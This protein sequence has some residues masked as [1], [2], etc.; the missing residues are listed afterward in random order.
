M[1]DLG[2]GGAQTRFFTGGGEPML[3][4]PGGDP[5]GRNEFLDRLKRE[6][7]GAEDMLRGLR[8]RGADYFMDASGGETFTREQSLR[9]QELKEQLVELDRLFAQPDHPDFLGYGTEER[10]VARDRYRDAYEEVGEISSRQQRMMFDDLRADPS[11]QTASPNW[12]GTKGS[13]GPEGPQTFG[14]G[15]EFFPASDANINAAIN[16]GGIIQPGNPQGLSGGGMGPPP[17]AGRA[18]T[19]A[20]GPDDFKQALNKLIGEMDALVQIPAAHELLDDLVATYSEFLDAFEKQYPV[21][22]AEWIVEAEPYIDNLNRGKRPRTIL[23]SDPPH[24]LDVT[25]GITG[26][27][28]MRR[29]AFKKILDKN[30]IGALTKLQVRYHQYSGDIDQTSA[31]RGMY[32]EISDQLR[33]YIA[34][35]QPTSLGPPDT[36]SLAVPPPGSVLDDDLA[37]IDAPDPRPR[38][39]HMPKDINAARI[40]YRGEMA[41]IEDLSM[42]IEDL[43]AEGDNPSKEQMMEWYRGRQI[44]HRNR[45]NLIAYTYSF[46]PE[47]RRDLEQ[48]G[49]A[50]A[51]SE[52]DQYADDALAGGGGAGKPPRT[53]F[54]LPDDW[55]GEGDDEIREMIERMLRGE[56]SPDDLVRMAGSKKWWKTI[57]R[58]RQKMQLPFVSGKTKA[59]QA[60]VGPLR[61]RFAARGPGPTAPVL[62]HGKPFQLAESIP[63]TEGPPV[64]PVHVPVQQP[65]DLR[66]LELFHGLQAGELDDASAAEINQLQEERLRSARSPKPK[67]RA[68]PKQQLTEVSQWLREAGAAGDGGLKPARVESLIRKLEAFN[69]ID[70]DFSYLYAIDDA[71]APLLNAPEQRIILDNLQLGDYLTPEQAKAIRFNISQSHS[72]GPYESVIRHFRYG[73][74]AR[75][76]WGNKLG[77]W[78]RFKG[79][80]GSATS[81][82]MRVAGQIPAPLRVIRAYPK[83]SGAVE[84]TSEIERAI[85]QARGAE[86]SW[87]SGRHHT[88]TELVIDLSDVVRDME[89]Y[90]AQFPHA[91]DKLNLTHFILL[92]FAEAGLITPQ[93]G[94][95]IA[96]IMEHMQGLG[97]D[98][99]VYRQKLQKLNA[100]MRRI[101]VSDSHAF[102]MRV[103]FKRP[104]D[105]SNAEAFF[106][107]M[108]RVPGLNWFQPSL[109]VPGGPANVDDLMGPFSSSMLRENG[110]DEVGIPATMV[111]AVTSGAIPAHLVP[112]IT[113][114]TRYQESYQKP[115]A[116]YSEGGTSYGEQRGVGVNIIGELW[117]DDPKIY[118]DVLHESID[119]ILDSE[120]TQLSREQ[121]DQ[122]NRTESGR[123]FL[124]MYATNGLYSGYSEFS[125]DPRRV[126]VGQ[127]DASQVPLWKWKVADD[128]YQKHFGAGGLANPTW[129]VY[130]AWKNQSPEERQAGKEGHRRGEYGEG[131]LA[132]SPYDYDEYFAENEEI[133]DEMLEASLISWPSG[134]R[135]R[136]ANDKRPIGE[137]QIPRPLQKV[138]TG[139]AMDV[140]GQPGRAR[141][142][143]RNE[144]PDE[145]KYIRWM[146]YLSAE[147]IFPE[148]KQIPGRREQDVY[149][150]TP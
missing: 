31:L 82:V 119:R 90:V 7:T 72:V 21:E 35:I 87:F 50:E 138:W 134:A 44:A 78:K 141:Y 26:S 60:M 113:P 13:T 148:V 14:P 81:G 105:P 54:D 132:S 86:T 68:I 46:S 10:Q 64:K 52:F 95:E 42:L 146:N 73:P 19:G 88:P 41:R 106:A 8:A 94:A 57:N 120:N 143:P 49:R 139:R 18:S 4:D 112:F 128:V 100:A 108:N 147:D 1:R 36:S 116:K 33:D 122:L 34:E 77:W 149:R 47:E 16:R 15:D 17:G 96:G 61:D 28:K 118:K 45:A 2:I 91:K 109:T 11:G 70:G 99:P 63:F 66:E 56:I 140:R 6:S 43:L 127:F 101:A 111:D 40:D 98:S 55:V 12:K 114:N 5:F 85:N 125:D 38:H 135:S 121:V 130:M 62:E 79:L 117:R 71:G 39:P 150:V 25:E 27:P 84:A 136:N 137:Y 59:M 65:I 145:D 37:D 80:S 124:E 93:T 97:E 123:K 129:H 3:P 92:R 102:G 74:N 30:G 83:L 48:Q 20:F 104:E 22:F 67:F 75:V 24:P 107:W 103:A 115:I 133:L 23:L 89:L 142:F 131:I 32:K 69:A 126:G 9:L 76:K 144:K 29:K 53:T 51:R 58:I 110:L